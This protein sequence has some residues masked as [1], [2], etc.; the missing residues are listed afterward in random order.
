MRA[1]ILENSTRFEVQPAQRTDGTTGPPDRVTMSV[2]TCWRKPPQ[3]L[4]LLYLYQH[5][6]V[7]Y[8]SI[9]GELKWES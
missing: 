9:E 5:N 8:Y 6:G 4:A 3:K 7:A 1:E 2:R